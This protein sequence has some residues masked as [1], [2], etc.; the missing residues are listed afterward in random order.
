MADT[1]A[2][3]PVVATS[4][5]DE[6]Y[7][8]AYN[9]YYQQYQQYQ[10]Q[11]PSLKHKVSQILNKQDFFSDMSTSLG[12]DTALILA[13]I[14]A[15]T[16]TFALIGVA[17]NNNNVNLLSGDQDSICTTAQ[18]FGGFT[19]TTAAST[20]TLPEATTCMATLAGYSTPSC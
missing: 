4:S 6:A 3:E 5:T 18:Q 15:L 12:P 2:G 19:C 20:I 14:G 8:Q 9:N 10:A 1:P 16:G 17:L 11:Q 7:A 13:A